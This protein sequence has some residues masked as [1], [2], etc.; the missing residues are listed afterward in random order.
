LTELRAK[1]ENTVLLP[2]PMNGSP[3]TSKINNS[4]IRLSR[5]NQVNALFRTACC[6]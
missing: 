1:H 6:P 5:I 3:S 4:G 2:M